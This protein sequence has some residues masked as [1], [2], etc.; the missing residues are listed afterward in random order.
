MAEYEM[1]EPESLEEAEPE[2]K[3]KVGNKDVDVDD[4][5][6][7]V[8]EKFEEAKDY[9]R[10]H[11]QHWLEAYDAYRGKYPSKISKAHELASERGIFVNQTRRKINSAK[12]KV[13]TLL[14]EDGKVPFSITPSRKPRFF[15]PDIQTPPD[16]PDLL[17]DALIERSKQMEFRIRDILERTNYNEEVQHAVHEMC[18]YGTGCT[19][20]IT[21]EYKNFPVYTTV[22]TPDE[23]VAIESTLEQ[24]LMPTCK[25][26]SI[27]NVFPSPEAINADDADYVIQRSFL[28]KIQLKKLAKTA[29]GFIPGSLEKVLEEEIGLNHGGDDSEHPK[30]Y[31][32]TSASRLKKFEVLEFWGRLDGDDLEPHLSIDSE[33]V[34]DVIPVVITVIGDKV[35]KIAEN[36][37]D[38]T[39]PFHFC[40][41][42]KNPE[43]IWGDGIYYAIRDAQAILNFSYA[44]MIE[45]KSLSAAPL[46][47]IDPNAFE[48]G[49][50]TEQIYPGKQFRVKPGA[51]VRDS[52]TSVQIPDVTNGLLSVIQQMEREADLDSGQTSIGYG[53]QSPSQTK[54]ATGMSILNSN[55]NRQTADVVRSVSSMITKNIGAVYRWLMVDSTDMSIKGDYEAISTG[56]E[57][58]VAK[59]VH[60]TQLINFLQVIGQFPE[61]K[62]YLKNEAFTRPLLRAFNM[63]PDKV[64][65]TEEEVTKEM[66]A[67]QEAQQK[68]IEA[69]TQAAQQAV[70][71]QL[72]QETQSKAQLAQQQ[73]QIMQAQTQAQMQ[74]SIAVEQNKAL[75]DEK[76]SIGEDQRKLEIQER[77]VLM[78]QGNV[79]HPAN[80]EN[81]SIML[82][83]EKMKEEAALTRIRSEESKEQEQEEL[84]QVMEQESIQEQQQQQQQGGMPPPQEEMQQPQGQMPEDPTQAGPAQERLQGGPTAQDIRQ[85][86]FAEN[87]PQ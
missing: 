8:Q 73:G 20:G 44:M 45:G 25:F 70:A 41:W 37:F 76:Q 5:A 52:F 65:K 31:N 61:I 55:A 48:P 81:Y 51:S 47:V 6:G 67:A 82:R 68:Q 58:Y 56:Y 11:E 29:E 15:P 69:Q 14:F 87:A 38:D 26:V 28:S 66:Q 32:E 59:E 60:N 13:N 33:D 19:K 10:D 71:Q 63:E 30:K 16:R 21:L 49:T 4:F 7:V 46:T 24:E 77:I 50:D 79:L 40:N 42:Q 74:S 12:I 80:L 17:D 1:E 43:S 27:W 86:E 85:R 64:V 54:T 83:D 18:L 34:P 78:N 84:R 23:M 22:Q 36:P 57:Q 72:Q 75:L 9:R 39:L 3:M 35:V 53:D 62:Q 2:G